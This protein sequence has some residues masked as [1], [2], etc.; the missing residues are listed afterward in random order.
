MK[1]YFAPP[2][3]VGRGFFFR[4]CSGDE[5]ST[6]VD[7][8]RPIALRTQTGPVRIPLEWR[9]TRVV[10]VITAYADSTSEAGSVNKNAEPWFSS[11]SARIV[12]PCASTMCLA[13]ARPS[14]VPPDSRERALSTR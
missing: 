9:P 12:P 2:H 7:A 1:V 8:N 13:M 11:L 14:P 3:S 10:P 4:C 6:S 5:K